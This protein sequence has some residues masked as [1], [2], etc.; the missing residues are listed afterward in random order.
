MAWY[1]ADLAECVSHCSLGNLGGCTYLHSE[2]GQF[3]KCF[4]C[5]AG[6]D[7]SSATECELGCQ[8][9]LNSGSFYHDLHYSQPPASPPAP[10]APASPWALGPSVE[11]RQLAIALAIVWGVR[12]AA[13]AAERGALDAL[14]L[15]VR[16]DAVVHLVLDVVA[17]ALL[18]E[19]RR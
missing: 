18:Y 12:L 3:N 14:V 9:A 8:L 7:S 5:Q 11:P 16:L 19:S 2:A 6:C 1:A 15:N 4:S 17:V 10:S 13:D